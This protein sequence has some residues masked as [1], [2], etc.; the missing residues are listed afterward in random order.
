MTAM[1]TSVSSVGMDGV[2]RLNRSRIALAIGSPVGAG[3]VLALVLGRVGIAGAV[4]LGGLIVAAGLV[5]TAR[6]A[7]ATVVMFAVLAESDDLSMFGRT[8]VLYRSVAGL[9]VSAFVGLITVAGAAAALLVIQGEAKLELP[10]LATAPLVVLAGAVVPGVLTGYLGGA[11]PVI[12]L[13]ELVGLA[14]LVTMTVATATLVANREWVRPAVVAAAAVAGV[15]AIEGFVSWVLHA[16]RPLGGTTITFYEPTPLWLLTLLVLFCIAAVLSR[17][18]LPRFVVP[19]ALLAALVIVLSLRRGFWIADVLSVTLCVVLA[20]GRT[21]RMILVFASLLVAAGAVVT[22]RFGGATQSS[23]VVLE[24][25]QSVTS[26]RRL[27]ASAEDR[28]RLDEQRNV[29]QDIALHP[30]TGVGLGGA[31]NGHSALSL[32]NPGGRYYTHLA[33]S[34]YWL[35]LGVLGAIAYLGLVAS[36]VAMGWR[37]WRGHADPL[38][39]AAGLAVA[40]GIIAIAV[41]ELTATFTGVSP[42][43]TVVIAAVIGWL[44]IA[45]HDA[46]GVGH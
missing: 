35:K 20:T 30:L 26:V 33:L 3:A 4:V 41:V 10:S 5:L 6:V 25:A 43:F 44:A 46:V 14:T 37:V 7:V 32:E 28:Y 21:N 34:W 45:D 13:S 42:R 1:R 12:I 29:R 22:L 11:N 19:A 40:I 24:R 8:A 38:V 17:A 18:A 39:R 23:N 16:G 15:K 36:C 9:P 31:W 2:E 27:S